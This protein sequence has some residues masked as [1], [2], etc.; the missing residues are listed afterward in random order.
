MAST[1]AF[2]NLLRALYNA[3]IEAQKLTEQQ[4]LRQ[5]RN[6]FYSEE[7]QDDTRESLPGMPKSL[8]IKVPNIRPD[9][10]DEW[11]D[12]DVPEMALVPPTSS[13]IKEMTVGF[14]VR[15]EGFTYDKPE[16]KGFAIQGQKARHRGPIV[17][18]FG[19][20]SDQGDP[21]LAKV[22]IV[23]EGADAPE[24]VHR[25]IDMLGKTIHY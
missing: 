17:V 24:S 8:T 18:D 15:M 14:N 4:H 3:V 10:E 13:Q 16:E 22:E 7:D 5:V 11:L 12:M 20:I 19:G 21:N 6:Y 1:D 23:F 2:D 9:A 25:L